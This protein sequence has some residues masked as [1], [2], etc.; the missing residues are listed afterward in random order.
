MKKWLTVS[1]IALLLIVSGCSQNGQ[2]S[3][4]SS[5]G[6]DSGNSGATE[7]AKSDFPKKPIEM[8]VPYEAGGANDVA[9]RI[10]ANAANKYMPNG[11]NIVIVNKPGGATIVG[12][13]EL[14]QAKPDGYKIGMLT[15]STLTNRPHTGNTTFTFD[16]FT[17]VIQVFTF[18]QT[19]FVKQDAPW[20]TFEEW[21]AYV[22]ANPGKF[23]YGIGASGSSAHLAM[24]SLAGR[25]GLD[26]KAVPFSGGAP[27]V[28][29]LMG[30]HVQGALLQST[31][32]PE[33]R[34]LVATSSKKSDLIKDVPLLTEKG[35]DVAFDEVSAILAPKDTPKEIVSILHDAVKKAMD[36]PQVKEELYKVGA[37]ELYASGEDFQK[38]VDKKFVE[39]GQLMKNLGLVK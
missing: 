14:F 25:A 4:G 2:T 16:S 18:P 32:A 36:D 7:A 10:I 26:M 33:A 8:I 19:L 1:L 30:G 29:A 13:T 24:A 31:L 15:I 34:K 27:T 22:K 17:P 39:N 12:A 5:T 28:T 23:T 9:A 37:D 38:E 11:Q 3:Q 21:L 35:F 6:T 20:K